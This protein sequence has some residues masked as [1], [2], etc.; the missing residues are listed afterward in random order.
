MVMKN[1]ERR[2]VKKKKLITWKI[3]LTQSCNKNTTVTI[4]TKRL[5]DV[6]PATRAIPKAISKRKIQIQ[7][8]CKRL[9][10]NN[11]RKIKG[12]NQ[13]NK[14]VFIRK[15][16]PFLTETCWKR[17]DTKCLVSVDIRYILL[18][19]I[20]GFI[21]GTYKILLEVSYKNKVNL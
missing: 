21:T 9:V 7:N 2:R 8:T 20:K 16:Y 12:N 15:T 13:L 4:L 1:L 3:I 10:R 6:S 17:L 14:D 18:N 19:P 11:Q 5:E